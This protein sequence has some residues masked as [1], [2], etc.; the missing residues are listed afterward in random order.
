M[1][2]VYLR[3]TF[4]ILIVPDEERVKEF[5]LKQMWKSPNGNIRNILGG[6]V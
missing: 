3:L 4:K 1:M 5:K 2:I 6:T